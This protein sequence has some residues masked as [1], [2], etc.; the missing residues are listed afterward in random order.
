MPVDNTLT[1]LVSR[2]RLQVDYKSTIDIKSTTLFDWVT[3]STANTIAQ[4]Q[5]VSAPG[6]TASQGGAL[7]RTRTASPTAC[8]SPNRTRIPRSIKWAAAH[9]NVWTH[10]KGQR[11]SF[12]QRWWVWYDATESVSFFVTGSSAL[13]K[14]LAECAPFVSGAPKFEHAENTTERSSQVAIEPASPIRERRSSTSSATGT[15]VAR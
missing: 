15:G 2:F 8:T 7:T 12:H 3:H 13:A 4:A 10:A 14:Q 1:R 5:P 6:R 9:P 11:V